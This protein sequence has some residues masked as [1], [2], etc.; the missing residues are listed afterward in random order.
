MSKI[1]E[2]NFQT[3][4]NL[5]YA[6]RPRLCHLKKWD[7][8]NGYGFNL[9]AERSKTSQHIGKVDLNSPAESAGLKEGD[10]II[11]VN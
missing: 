8:F 9:H 1:E 10:R 11:E 7:N 6:V 5:P 2:E 4:I 3:E